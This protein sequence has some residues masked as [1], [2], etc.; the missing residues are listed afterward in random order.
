MA[1]MACR[2]RMP[3]S[4]LVKKVTRIHALKIFLGGLAV[5]GAAVLS[6]ARR[7]LLLALLQLAI[8]LGRW[9]VQSLS[10]SR[11]TRHVTRRYTTFDRRARWFTREQARDTGST[12]Q[13]M[14]RQ[15][16]TIITSVSGKKK[17][18]RGSNAENSSWAGFGEMMRHDCCARC[19]FKDYGHS[20]TLKPQAHHGPAMMSL[21]RAPMPCPTSPPGP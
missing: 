16:V 3:R 14:N 7:N 13:Q 19:L 4:R 2:Q 10:V 9:Q 20:T 8:H 15:G 11:R 21:A 6:H 12:Q 1:L 17:E 18:V 5:R